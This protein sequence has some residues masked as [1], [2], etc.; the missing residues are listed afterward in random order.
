M[1]KILSALFVLGLMFSCGKKE[2]SQQEETVTPPYTGEGE[3]FLSKQTINCEAGAFCPDY[4]AKIVVFDKG[5]VRY[6][7]GTLVGRSKLLTSTSCLPTYLRSTEAECSKYIHIFFS[8]GTRPPERVKCEAIL[9]VSELD[10]NIAEYWRDDVAVIELSEK[11]WSRDYKDISRKG[12]R[13]GDKVR[14]YGVEQSGDFTGV[15]R[16]EECESVL[17]SYLYPLSSSESSPNIL[18]AGCAR[19]TGYRGAAILDSFPRIRAVL[20]ENSSLRASL[21]NSSL[22]IKPLKDF[23]NVSNFACAPFLDENS[24]LSEQECAKPL[25]YSAVAGGRSQLLSDE[26]RYGSLLSN[27]EKT[28]NGLS[29]YYKIQLSLDQAGDRQVVSYRPVCFKNVSSWLS[30][31][32]GRGEV[33][34]TP[35]FPIRALRKGV[36]SYGRAVTQ[37]GE[38][39]EEKYYLTFSGKRLYKEKLSDV[40]VSTDTTDTSRLSK[41]RACP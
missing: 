16:K 9:Q 5:S 7:T 13:D 2:A 6:C 24:A 4:V 27:L 22:L 18:L 40:F 14:F 31:V 12:F 3:E 29:K 34:E 26:V 36:D 41:I 25:D 17:N 32:K 1:V 19:K 11:L 10:G 39:A 37:E 33:S 38:T 21:A 20:S 30:E 35:M 15:I 23:I 8:R 28:A